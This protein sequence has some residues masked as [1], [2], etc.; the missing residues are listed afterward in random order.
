MDLLA[1]LLPQV[2]AAVLRLLFADASAEFHLRELTRRSSLALG[3][4]QTELAKLSA[5]QLVVSERDGNRRYYRANAAHPLFPIL[6][7]LVLRAT[8]AAPER[9]I[10]APANSATAATGHRRPDSGSTRPPR[11][12]EPATPNQPAQSATLTLNEFD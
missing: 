10:A 12:P 2:R 3:T 8:D 6:Q 11:Y 7:Q 1:V 4:L 5:A 9:R